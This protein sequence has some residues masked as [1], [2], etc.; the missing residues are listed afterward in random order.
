[1]SSFFRTEPSQWSDRTGTEIPLRMLCHFLGFR[2]WDDE[3]RYY[4][5]YTT[6]ETSAHAVVIGEIDVVCVG[7]GGLYACG[8]EIAVERFLFGDSAAVAKAEEEK[9]R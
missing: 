4:T 9:E 1:V 7:G 8:V 2:G 6:A 5:A 3:R